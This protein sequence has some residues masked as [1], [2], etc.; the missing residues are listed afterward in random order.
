MFFIRS[1][2]LVLLVAYRLLL[3]YFFFVIHQSMHQTSK[4]IKWKKT[5]ARGGRKP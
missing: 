3:S 2:I 5:N 4:S 1:I